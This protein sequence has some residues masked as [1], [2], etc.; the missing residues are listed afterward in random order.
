MLGMPDAE[1]CALSLAVA[2]PSM[3]LAGLLSVCSEQL[4][5]PLSETAQLHVNFRPKANQA[6]LLR[7]SLP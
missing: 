6:P 1:P 4:K 2:C 7:Q 3:V 5:N